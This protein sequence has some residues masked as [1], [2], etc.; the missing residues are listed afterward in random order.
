MKN[1][2]ANKVKLWWHCLFR[3]HQ[4][5]WMEYNDGEE[6][7]FCYDCGYGTSKKDKEKLGI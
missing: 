7:I 1:T 2:V 5:M 3:F 6:T 4:E